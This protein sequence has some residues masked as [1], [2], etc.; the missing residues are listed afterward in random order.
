VEIVELQFQIGLKNRDLKTNVSVKKIPEISYELNLN[1]SLD[2]YFNIYLYIDD[3]YLLVNSVPQLVSK[4]IMSNDT[5]S[6]SNAEIIS[7]ISKFIDSNIENLGNHEE[8]LLYQKNKNYKATI[9]F[10]VLE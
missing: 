9:V 10:L 6:V 2:L 1:S 3:R 7:K 5:V 8:I 4:T